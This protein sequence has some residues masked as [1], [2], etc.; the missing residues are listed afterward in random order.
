MMTAA[1]GRYDSLQ[2]RCFSNPLG[3]RRGRFHLDHPFTF[4]FFTPATSHSHLLHVSCSGSRQEGLSPVKAQHQGVS[5]PC[6]PT[7]PPP[8]LL[9]PS[10]AVLAPLFPQPPTSNL[11][12]SKPSMAQVRPTPWIGLA[13][14]VITDC[15]SSETSHFSLFTAG[16]D[17]GGWHVTSE[18]WSYKLAITPVTAA[19]LIEVN[20]WSEEASQGEWCSYSQMTQI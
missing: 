14:L 13:Q 4:Q 16:R 5:T 20:F 10:Q 17:Q 11:C 1:A 15:S 19:D 7:H 6:P 12:I 3:R 2:L 8:H 18:S 9:P